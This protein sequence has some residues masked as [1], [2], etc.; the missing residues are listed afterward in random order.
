MLVHVQVRDRLG[1]IEPNLQH[2]LGLP[3][4]P[5][6]HL[7]LLTARVQVDQNGRLL[8][9]SQCDVFLWRQARH[10]HLVGR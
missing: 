2:Q 6:W 9:E 5:G 3:F 1:H 10:G 8:E 7:H 4:E